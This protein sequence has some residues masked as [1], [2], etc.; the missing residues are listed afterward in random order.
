LH[1]R[2]EDPERHGKHHCTSYHVISSH[3]SQSDTI[4][5]AFADNESLQIILEDKISATGL[6]LPI[7][8]W[9]SNLRL[10]TKD[11]R[12]PS[13]D[14]AVCNALAQHVRKINETRVLKASTQMQI[15][16]AKKDANN[17]I[18]T[19]QKQITTQDTEKRLFAAETQE[20]IWRKHA[21]QQTS[22]SIGAE[23]RIFVLHELLKREVEPLGKRLESLETKLEQA[24]KHDDEAMIEKTAQDVSKA[25]AQVKKVE[26]K[27]SDLLSR[28]F[29]I[30]Q[31][32]VKNLQDEKQKVELELAK[33]KVA[34]FTADTLRCEA[35]EVELGVLRVDHD[36]LSGE[37]SSLKAKCVQLEAQ[38]AELQAKHA[39][40]KK[41]HAILEA[42]HLKLQGQ[43]S[44][45][46]TTLKKAVD[47]ARA[48]KSSR[49]SLVTGGLDQEVTSPS[50]DTGRKR[51]APE[52]GE[53]NRTEKRVKMDMEAPEDVGTTGSLPESQ[54]Y[55]EGDE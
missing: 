20:K 37:S 35:L 13:I 42:K 43:H 45:V 39:Q 55:P 51:A 49:S 10:A 5:Q 44:K 2:S 21:N 34:T 12:R 31:T 53:V 23:E 4:A 3:I 14:D 30:L 38:Y 1:L 16:A 29:N 52:E 47:M 27:R 9:F 40:L 28:E 19:A 36:I 22:L 26:K 54:S 46:T 41:D 7:P 8:N 48:K 11:L 18:H 17:A 24:Q 32:Q 33:A 50:A 6:D 25:R 15:E